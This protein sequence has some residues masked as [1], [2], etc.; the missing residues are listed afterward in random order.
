MRNPMNYKTRYGL[1]KATVRAMDEL[2]T[3]KK[4]WWLHQ[5]LYHCGQQF[6]DMLPQLRQLIGRPAT[7][8]DLD[9]L[10]EVID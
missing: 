5:A 8:K 9:R 1:Y 10:N 3:T 7:L 2:S 4:A 6:P